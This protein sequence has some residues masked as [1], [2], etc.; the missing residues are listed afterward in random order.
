MDRCWGLTTYNNHRVHVKWRYLTPTEFHSLL[1][2]P[3]DLQ[4][5]GDIVQ[6]DLHGLDISTELILQEWP[7]GSQGG[8]QELRLTALHTQLQVTYQ[9]RE[10][11]VPC[12]R[13]THLHSHAHHWS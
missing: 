5:D 12:C 6:V 8:G 1:V 11:T 3:A 13:G 9:R 2:P 4:S 10:G 7:Q